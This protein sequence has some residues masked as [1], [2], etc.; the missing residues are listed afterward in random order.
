M[1]VVR[2]IGRNFF[3][4]DRESHLTT[5]LEPAFYLCRSGSSYLSEVLF[6]KMWLLNLTLLSVALRPCFLPRR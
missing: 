5:R 6:V 1:A 2:P 3:L 4:S